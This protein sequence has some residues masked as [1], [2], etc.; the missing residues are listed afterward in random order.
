MEHRIC[1]SAEESPV[2]R[3]PIKKPTI[4]YL[5]INSSNRKGVW[6]WLAKTHCIW[7]AD[8]SILIRT[9]TGNSPTNLNSKIKAALWFKTITTKVQLFRILTSLN[10]THL[11]QL[12]GQIRMDLHNRPLR[13]RLPYILKV[14]VELDNRRGFKTTLLDSYNLTLQAVIRKSKVFLTACRLTTNKL[15]RE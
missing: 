8:L 3:T 6:S 7:N 1:M 15:I 13:K 9:I 12:D 2:T 4:W 5:R 11:P 14:L 10:Y